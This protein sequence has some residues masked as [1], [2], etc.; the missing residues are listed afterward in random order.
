MEN[1]TYEQMEEMVI[2]TSYI[3]SITGYATVYTCVLHLGNGECVTGVHKNQRNTFAPH[4]AKALSR[5]EAFI[6]LKSKLLSEGE[7]DD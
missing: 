4:A 2:D 1:L 6:N 3:E 5:T 7:Q